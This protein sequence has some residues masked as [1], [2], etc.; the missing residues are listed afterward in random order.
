MKVG[1]LLKLTSKRKGDSNVSPQSFSKYL[2]IF[3]WEKI[4]LTGILI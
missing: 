2:Q 4:I 3:R 1:H